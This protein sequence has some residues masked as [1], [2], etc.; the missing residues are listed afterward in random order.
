MT[1]IKASLQK[2][3]A[4]SFLDDLER[5]ENQYFLFFAKGTTWSNDNSPPS[6]TDTV[7]AEYDVMNNI[8]GYKKINSQNVVF[9][10]PR[11]EWT[12]GI[13]Y[14]Q[15]DDTVELFAENNP[16]IFYVVTDVHNIYKCIGNSGGAIH[17]QTK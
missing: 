16:K 5:K 12:A 17:C 3:Y 2:S 8:I 9:A 1:L 14:D 15:Y 10:L 7:A 11:Y 6:Y 13:S 4:E